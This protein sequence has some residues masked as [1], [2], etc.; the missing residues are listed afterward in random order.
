[1]RL[2]FNISLAT[3]A[4]SSMLIRSIFVNTSAHRSTFS[5]YNKLRQFVELKE[6]GGFQVEF[7]AKNPNQEQ[8]GEDIL[9]DIEHDAIALEIDAI[10]NARDITP[11][12]QEE[13]DAKQVK[14][15]EEENALAKCRYKALLGDEAFTRENVREAYVKRHLEKRT[16][17][18]RALNPLEKSISD[19]QHERQS[20]RK[21][22]TDYEHRT[23]EWELLFALC[24][25]PEFRSSELKIAVFC[26]GRPIESITWRSRSKSACSGTM[27]PVLPLFKMSESGV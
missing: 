25:A 13:I 11:L 6:D 23:K 18:R 10:M 17:V 9:K 5:K 21:V 7:V 1:M 4:M 8:D 3:V 15:R 24:R 27:F 12:E 19:D 20:R 22:V 14:T 26:R 2:V 16:R